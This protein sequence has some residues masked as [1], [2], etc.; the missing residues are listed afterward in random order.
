M[1]GASMAEVQARTA[2]VVYCPKCGYEGPIQTRR[3]DSEQL[4]KAH[5]A[6]A[7]EPKDGES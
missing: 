2:W 6:I 7:H 4:A 5:E 3:D 1:M